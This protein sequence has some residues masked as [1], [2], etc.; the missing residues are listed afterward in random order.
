MRVHGSRRRHQ[1]QAPVLLLPPRQRFLLNV[2]ISYGSEENEKRLRECRV[3][4]LKPFTGLVK[5]EASW[6]LI[7]LPVPLLP[8][9]T[10]KASFQGS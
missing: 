7:W 5:L 9:S 6:T 2:G 10:P 4:L 1:T 8:V 3:S